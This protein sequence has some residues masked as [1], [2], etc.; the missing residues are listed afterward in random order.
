MPQR[1]GDGK[2]FERNVVA[3][4]AGYVM[5]ADGQVPEGIFHVHIE[6]PA[7]AGAH[8]DILLP[9]L[10]AQEDCAYYLEVT[11][12]GGAGAFAVVQDNDD[13][14]ADYTSANLTAVGDFVYVKNVA[15]RRMIELA[16]L[17]TP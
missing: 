1:L 6:L 10:A 14:V 13:G 4:G 2:D 9:P 15:G 12:A 8:I 7:G 17:S 3:D 11:K 16:E 5:D